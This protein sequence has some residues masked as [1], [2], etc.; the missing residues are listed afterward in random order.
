MLSPVG[1]TETF[2]RP[3]GTQLL[4]AH[5]S[6]HWS[7]GLLSK[8]PDGTFQTASQIFRLRVSVL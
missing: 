4:F 3:D 8:V 2:S 6:Q 5:G 7:A 1:T